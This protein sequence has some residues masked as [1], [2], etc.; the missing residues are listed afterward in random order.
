MK[1]LL[2]I[3]SLII[4]A[5]ACEK[6]PEQQSGDQIIVL[7]EAVN[8]HI[9][10]DDV[11]S[12]LL[13]LTLKGQG[14]TAS[15]TLKSNQ[16][17]LPA[18]EFTVAADAEGKNCKLTLNDGKADKEVSSGKIK[19][20]EE[21]GIYTINIDVIVGVS[22]K[23]SLVYEGAIEFETEIAS[24]QDIALTEVESSVATPYDD[25]SFKL[26][27]SLKGNG[28]KVSVSL[29]N[30]AAVL[31][32]RTFTAVS[33]ISEAGHCKLILNDGSKDHEVVHG[34]MTI[35]SENGVY[36]IKI[37]AAVSAK[38]KYALSYTGAVAFD[39]DFV[40]SPYTLMATEANITTWEAN[41][42]GS[43]SEVVIS[44][45]SKYSIRLIDSSDNTIAVFE[46]I[47]EPGKKIT[48]L[49]GEYTVGSANEIGTMLKGASSWGSASG[50]YFYDSQ[51][52]QTFI[53]KGNVIITRMTDNDGNDYYTFTGKEVT[54]KSADLE[55]KY[56]AVEKF[57]GTVIRNST[58]S[59]KKMNKSMKYSIYLPAGY[60][61]GTSYPIL[62]LLHGYGDENNAWLDKGN[63][64]M[65]ARTYE[66][67]GGNPMIVVMPDGLAEFYQGRW[68]NYMYEELMPEVETKYKFN[69]KRAVSGLSM[70]GYGTL[71]YWCKYSDMYKYAYAMSP[72]VDVNGTSKLL[73]GKD[74]S[75]LPALT[76]ET[77]IQDQTTTL[78]S[79]TE[80]HEYLETE[81]ID[82]EW[83]TRDGS[84]DWTFWQVC[85]PKALDKCGKACE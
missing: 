7:D 35:K 46:L 39:I 50:S 2:C 23:Y 57:Q 62:Y 66:K 37:E 17:S 77:G 85:L 43:Y 6:A 34:S 13:N 76:I 40:P 73:V 72:A 25:G 8:G 75:K 12:F 64:F 70:G 19:I 44:G 33:E 24:Y 80:F 32:E 47:S 3:L 74:K 65:T 15:L 59:S 1:R 26:D 28:F 58:I 10:E 54:S 81:E 63:L 16:A 27:L 21:S 78:A 69:G 84:H 18:G 49:V 42:W 61:D 83:I 4:F 11:N 55:I 30:P 38:E 82:H 36:T 22:S 31:P 79:I 60:E 20:A 56:A 68:E 45:I 41:N 53:T 9:I 48:D 14:Y 29:D 5:F 67:N 52:A 51:N 71:Y